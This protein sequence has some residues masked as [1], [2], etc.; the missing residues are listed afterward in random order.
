MAYPRAGELCRPKSQLGGK[1][2]K[3]PARE[4]WT[5]LAGPGTFLW[6]NL[7]YFMFKIYFLNLIP[8]KG[9]VM[10]S[11]GIDRKQEKELSCRP[12]C[13]EWGLGTNGFPCKPWLL[14]FLTPPPLPH[15]VSLSL[16]VW[17]FLKFSSK[18]ISEAFFWIFL[19]AT[20]PHLPFPFS[21]A[22]STS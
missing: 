6:F 19:L 17:P 15:K 16:K 5:M 4:L 3:H 14:F 12:R 21:T 7:N 20:L 13:L 9:E 22:S 10:S 11:G 2:I 1:I 18:A 8:K